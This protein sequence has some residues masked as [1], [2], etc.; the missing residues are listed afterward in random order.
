MRKI[1]CTIWLV[2]RQEPMVR[3]V[4]FVKVECGFVVMTEKEDTVQVVPTH[5]VKHIET[6]TLETTDGEDVSNLNLGEFIE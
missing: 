3:Y 2:G 5:C 6:K 4:D 1:K